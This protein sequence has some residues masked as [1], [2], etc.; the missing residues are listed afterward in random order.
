M[1]STPEQ[2]TA[3]D[4][5]VLVE[6]TDGVRTITLNRPAAYNSLNIELKNRLV[7]TLRDTASDDD[8]RAVVLTGA[9]KAFCAGQDLK[10]H[11]GLL[12]DKDPAPL[13]TVEEHYNP[14]ATS[15][16]EM[17]K[18]II[19]AVNGPAAGAG[20]AFAYAADVRVAASSANF[21]M[22]FANVGLGPDSGASWTLQRLIGYGRALELMMLPRK[23][24]A[25]EALRIGLVSEIIE[26]TGNGEVLARARELA[27]KLATGPTVAY[28]KIK[29]TLS[30]ATSSS[31]REALAAEQVA[32]NELGATSDHHEAVD[33][34]VNKRDPKFT[35]A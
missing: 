9:G 18:P 14:I 5:V 21:L 23:V 12:L 35:G 20:A 10:E 2:Q 25:D 16:A 33:A 7:E 15:I 31:F 29:Q 11:V 17:P 13:S 34:F 27:A 26:D 22:A 32:Q 30:A 6:D 1:P 8:V 3:T 28:Q 24:H 19:A 4:D